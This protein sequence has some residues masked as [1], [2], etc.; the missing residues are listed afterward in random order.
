[1]IFY[2][3][4]YI[5]SVENLD[6][7][8]QRLAGRSI[9]L[10]RDENGAPKFRVGNS[11]IAF[12]VM[13]DGRHSA[14]RVYIRTHPNLEAIYGERYFPNELMVN[15][16]SSSSGFADVV[17]CDWFEGE[18]LQCKI[19]Q[20]AENKSKMSALSIDFERLAL[21]LLNESWAHGDLKPENIILSTDGLHLIDFDAMY[22]PGFKPCNCVESGTR[23]Y[24]HPGRDKTYFD[25][26]IDD[27]PIALISTALAAL[28]MDSR[29]GRVLAK[30]DHLLV[31]PHLAVAGKD[32]VLQRIENLFAEQGDIRHYRISRLLHSQ[33]PALPQLKALLEMKV[34]S[35]GESEML[36]A[37]CRNGGWGYVVDGKF[38]IPPCYDLAFD[39]S[40][41]LGLVRIADV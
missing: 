24:Q 3:S 2:I 38:V 6:K 16:T 15:A 18:S 1:M 10:L 11:V 28:S 39:F 9:A 41:G 21:S 33:Q 8:S 20:F 13:C 25:K 30:S 37:E 26:S 40:E 35:V 4:Q 22:C 32:N 23:Q 5:L 34:R 17:L 27:Y 31:T 19:E 29:L 12:E 14:L 7:M 36:S